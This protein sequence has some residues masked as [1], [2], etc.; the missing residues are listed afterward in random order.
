MVTHSLVRTDPSG[1]RRF[2][3]RLGAAVV[4]TLLVPRSSGAPAQTPGHLADLSLLN[5]E[6]VLP[7]PPSP[8]SLA[9][10]ADLETVLEVQ[11]HRTANEIRWAKFIQQFDPW[12][13]FGY[14]GLLG[15]HFDR[16][17]L[18]RVAQ[19]MSEVR[20]LSAE[21]K[22][23]KEEFARPRPFVLDPRVHPCITLPTDPSYPSGHTFQA[24][25]NAELL[26]AIFPERRDAIMERAQ[27]VG[28]GRIVAGVHFPTDIE[29]GRRLA[30]AVMRLEF[31]NPQFQALIA[32]CRQEASREQSQAQAQA[33]AN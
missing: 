32:E 26:A 21:Y 6:Q 27:E 17:H 15:P 22:R 25:V 5:I 14:G 19:A 1:L 10:K 7:P 11:A 23:A 16:A 33:S 20:T 29:A 24:Y 13:V 12:A 8:D 28:W 18:P 3:I 31:K 9:G 4:F 30:E 2:G